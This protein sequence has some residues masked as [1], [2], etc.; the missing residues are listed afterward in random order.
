MIVTPTALIPAQVAQVQGI[1][2]EIVSVSD[3]DTLTIRLIGGQN[4]VI[5]LACIDAPEKNQPGGKESVQ[6]L[7]TLLPRGEIV[8]FGPVG[9]KDQYGAFLES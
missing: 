6:R 5:K 7:S 9:D 3:G 8:A 2:A 1:Y 4:I